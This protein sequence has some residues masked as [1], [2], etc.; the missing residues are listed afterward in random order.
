MGWRADEL[1]SRWG[2]EPLGWRA[3]G[4]ASRWGRLL[5]P[6]YALTT[7]LVY[8][9]CSG[10]PSCRSNLPR[11]YRCEASIILM[12]GCCGSDYDTL[13]VAYVSTRM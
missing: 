1:E 8:D 3:V 5:L 13:V 2:S 7:M 11:K 6:A 10:G 9:M 12:A 4:V